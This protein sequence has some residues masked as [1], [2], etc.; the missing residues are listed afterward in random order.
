MVRERS[1]ADG[2]ALAALGLAWLG[3]WGA[4]IPHR[5]ASLTQ[6]AIDLAQWAGILNDVRFGSLGHVPDLLRLAVALAG[7]A[8]AVGAGMLHNHWLRWGVRL[9]ALLPGLV[10]LPP[11]P[12]VLQLWNSDEYGRRFVIASFLWIGVAASLLTDRL[13]WQMRRALLAGLG[14]AAAALG[15]GTFLALRHPFEAHYASPVLPGW[16]VLAFV[17]GL[18][19]ASV[20]QG[21]GLARPAA[22]VQA[23]DQGAPG[24]QNAERVR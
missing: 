10:L 23:S 5:T 22:P 14:V 11:Y 9:A 13:A 12:F 4:W 16:G 7:V 2:A 18:A 6:N 17:V 8:L 24:P 19:A 20:I 21:I 3:I 15:A 1:R